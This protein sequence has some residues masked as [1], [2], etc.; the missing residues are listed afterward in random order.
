[1]N[2]KRKKER[3]MGIMGAVNGPTVTGRLPL[4][5]SDI[6]PTDSRK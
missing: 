5:Q 6:F 1:M 2:V 3:K 4:F